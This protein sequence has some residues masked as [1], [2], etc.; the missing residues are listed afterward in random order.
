VKHLQGDDVSGFVIKGPA[1]KPD[2]F[3]L[4]WNWKFNTFLRNFFTK[5]IFKTQNILI[6]IF[7][8]WI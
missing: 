8:S 2:D 4:E 5:I 3:K 1:E 7:T 6:T